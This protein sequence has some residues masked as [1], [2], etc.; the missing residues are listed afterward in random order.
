MQKPLNPAI[1]VPDGASRGRVIV[2]LFVYNENNNDG[3]YL[4]ELQPLFHSSAFVLRCLY[5]PIH[6]AHL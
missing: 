6:L 3:A 5:E 1:M 2:L 4:D